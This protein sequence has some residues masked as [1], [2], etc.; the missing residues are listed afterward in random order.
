MKCPYCGT[1]NADNSVK[2]EKCKAK[3]PE[4]KKEAEK[5]GKIK[6]TTKK[7]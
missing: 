6:E 5:P 1:K 4:V 3:L 2:C 7:E